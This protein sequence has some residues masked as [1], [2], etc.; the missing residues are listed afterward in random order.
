MEEGSGIGGGFAPGMTKGKVCV[1]LVVV[2]IWFHVCIECVGFCIFT[3]VVA[4]YSIKYSFIVFFLGTPLLESVV[5]S[6]SFAQISLDPPILCQ[7]GTV[8][9]FFG[10]N[11]F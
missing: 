6:M 8:E 7:T 5:F 11:S 2:Y 3:T 4:G 1:C 10:H 9:H